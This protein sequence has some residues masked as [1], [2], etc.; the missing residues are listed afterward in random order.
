MNA[1]NMTSKSALY[2]QSQHKYVEDWKEISAQRI[3]QPSHF[4]HTSQGSAV[5][6][7]HYYQTSEITYKHSLYLQ[8]TRGATQSSIR[9]WIFNK[10]MRQPCRLRL[11]V[12]F[13]G[14]FIPWTAGWWALDKT[15]N[16]RLVTESNVQE[17][18]NNGPW[19]SGSS[20]DAAGRKIVLKE[21]IW[22]ETC[23]NKASSWILKYTNIRDV[24]CCLFLGQQ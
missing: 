20:S 5:N 16:T 21:T 22:L 12:L 4:T 8:N 7:S 11:A 9:I 23:I 3:L 15:H 19:V 24:L 6:A 10:R 18:K 13:T 2:S 14:N 17:E 1:A